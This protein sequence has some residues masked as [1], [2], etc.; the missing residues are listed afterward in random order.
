MV[1]SPAS[2]SVPPW[3]I[4]GKAALRQR[5][6]GKLPARWAFTRTKGGEIRLQLKCLPDAEGSVPPVE[7]CNLPYSFTRDGLGRA[8]ELTEAI[9][10]GVAEGHSLKAALR[11]ATLTRVA[12]RG[13]WGVIAA[14]FQEL[15]DTLRELHRPRHLEACL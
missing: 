9:A 11:A 10:A 8:L 4:T 3:E 15:Q 5:A 12:E 2:K 6:N 7:S 13:E 14:A 1:R